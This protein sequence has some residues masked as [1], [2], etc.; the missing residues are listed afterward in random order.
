MS[1]AFGWVKSP[2][3]ASPAPK[4]QTPASGFADAKKPYQAPPSR[5]AP[6]PVPPPRSMPSVPRAAAAPT[7]R[8]ALKSAAKNVLIVVLDLTGSMNEW[9]P[10]LFRRLPL[11]F[12]EAAKYLG[13]DDLEILFAAHGDARTDDRPL[14]V[15][16]FGRGAELDGLLASFHPVGGGGGGGQGTESQEL[17]ALYLHE[18]VDT[19]SARHVHAFFVTDEMACGRAD[20]DLARTH[21]GIEV[22][23]ALRDTKALFRSLARRMNA[24]A[25]LCETGTYDPAPIR[26]GWEGLVGAERILPLDDA[27]RVADVLLG[28]LAAQ[29]GQ[30]DAFTA[31]LVSR[32]GG[33][34][35]ARQNVQTVLSSIALVAN[36]PS[37]AKLPAGPGTRPLLPAHPPSK[38]S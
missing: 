17:M 23:D 12:N 10:E 6:D 15:T 18:L 19:A 37:V 34:R 31:D 11:L 24:Y 35:F 14:Q 26:K 36:G 7:A 9:P 22:P 30:L 8:H 1:G 38:K 32:Q 29:T 33:S 21:L 20:P 4:S 25:V 3:P 2:A 28:T 13:S 16:R 5:R 27:R